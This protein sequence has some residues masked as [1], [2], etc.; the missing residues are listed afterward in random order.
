MYSL[1]PEPGLPI[2]NALKYKWVQ[3]EGAAAAA[4]LA[5][6][7]GV[8]AAGR[9]YY[10]RWYERIWELCWARFVDHKHGR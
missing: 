2:G 7:P 10:L 4:L 3:T 5:H 8:D 9:E 1:R 6:A